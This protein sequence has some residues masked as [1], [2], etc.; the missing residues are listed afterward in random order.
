M[1]GFLMVMGAVALI[2]G[3]ACAAVMW[4]RGRNSDDEQW[5]DDYNPDLARMESMRTG[6]DGSAMSTEQPPQEAMQH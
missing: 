6:A 2:G 3:L 5:E 1:K 4:M